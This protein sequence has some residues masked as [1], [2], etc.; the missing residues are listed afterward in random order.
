MKF[1]CDSCNAQ[2]MI[3]DEKVGKRGVKVKCKRCSHVIIVRPA[4]APAAKSAAAPAAPA[5][6][7]EQGVPKLRVEQP[8]RSKVAPTDAPPNLDSTSPGEPAHIVKSTS[9]GDAAGPARPAPVSLLATQTEVHGPGDAKAS[10]AEQAIAAQRDEDPKSTQSPS[11]LL[12]RGANPEKTEVQAVNAQARDAAA[13]AP[14]AAAIQAPAKGESTIGDALDDQLAGAFNQMFDDKALPGLGTLSGLAGLHDSDEDAEDQ[15]GPTRILDVDA[16]NALRKQTAAAAAPS[17]V[18]RDALDSLRKDLSSPNEESSGLWNEQHANAVK[19]KAKAVVAPASGDD[20]PAKA[21]WHAAVDDEDI[22]P[23]TLAELGRQIEDGRIDRDSLVWKSGME[24]WLPAGEVQDVSA[25]FDRVPRPKIEADE[26]SK[27]KNAKP[28]SFDVGAPFDDMGNGSSPFDNVPPMEESDPAWRPHGLTDV[29]Q[30][31]NLAEA[32]GAGGGGMGLI[33]GSAGMTARGG[34]PSAPPSQ[35][36]AEWRPSASSALASLVSNE[37]ERIAKGP[38]PADD[39]DLGA[40]RPADDASFSGGLPFSNLRGVD[41][42]AGPEMSDPGVHA[43]GQSNFGNRNQNQNQNQN[44]FNQQQQFGQPSF[45][46][47]TAQS[48]RPGWVYPA[49]F[50]IAFSVVAMLGFVTIKLAL[51]TPPAPQVVMIGSDGR[52]L[53]SL[54]APTMPTTPTTPDPSTAPNTP[55]VAAPNTPN[56]PAVAAAAAAPPAQVAADNAGPA[57]PPVGDGTAV[58]ASAD[59]S[60]GTAALKISRENKLSERQ[61][62]VEKVEKVAKAEKVKAAGCDPLLD[63]DCKPG[64]KTADASKTPI[65]E[66]IGKTDILP[67]VRDALPKVKACGAKFKQTGS[68]KMSWKIDKSGKP[69]D[70][71]VADL[72]FGGTPVGACVTAVVKAMKFP[73]YSGKAPA[74]VSIPLPLQ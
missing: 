67:V 37:I 8:E 53:Q 66:T 72:T 20:G 19:S 57:T 63:I 35:G 44:G 58:V 74:P 23:L 33:G 51:A 34:G 56:T 17:V 45:A 29:Y 14:V 32:A 52:A 50:M 62:K 11:A 36:E 49:F 38:L 4:G 42:D 70:V 25:L 24:N 30:A 31:A 68:I 71:A 43:S 39:D 60:K 21:V 40:P 41:L 55:A 54:P 61:E 26:T 65:K 18:D 28:S 47:P 12:G 69:Q 16:M 10:K 59:T 22:G 48:S 15:R 27:R 6:P 13:P 64:T 7:A 73:A 46:S 9:G 2:Y 5:A 1:E 3:A